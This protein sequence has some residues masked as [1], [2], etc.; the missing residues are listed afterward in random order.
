MRTQRTLYLEVGKEKT[1]LFTLQWEMRTQRTLYLEMGDE[2]R[3]K[4]VP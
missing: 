2:N 4:C 1:D 3:G